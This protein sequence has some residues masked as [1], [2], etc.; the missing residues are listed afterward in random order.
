MANGAIYGLIALG[1]ALLVNAVNILNFAQGE[2]VMLGAFLA[3][4][5]GAMLKLPFPVALLL[6]VAT[7]ALIGILFERTVYRPIKKGESATYL[8]ATIA[9]SVTI[10]NLA[11]NIW[12]SVP[13]AYNEPFGRQVLKAGEL[14]VLPQHLFILLVTGLL[15]AA[16]WFFFFHTRL[17]KLMRATAQDRQTARLLGI[18]VARIGTITF[19][20]AASLGSLAGV[21]VAPIFFV[22]LDMGFSMGL[23]AFVASIIGGWGSV[24]GA[25]V[26]GVLLG[27]VEQLATGY[28][29]S[30]YKDAFAFLILIGFL[31]FLPRGVFGEKVA[32]KA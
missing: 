17:G 3:Y 32:D 30:K 12:G 23:K 22:N 10:R 26:G 29:S 18:R 20:M 27:T 14:V 7:A 13:F 9:A 1:F 16:L 19:M 6:V 21:L 15:V 11:Q 25:I 28:L 31:V 2:F 24:P 5:F 8:V 4:T